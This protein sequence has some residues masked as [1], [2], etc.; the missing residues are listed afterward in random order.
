MNEMHEANRKYWD[1]ATPKW[2][3]LDDADWRKCPQKPS[4]AFEGNV[5]DMINEFIGNLEG[6]HACVIGSGDNYA[7]FALAGLGAVVTSTDI[8]EQ[9]LKVAEQRANILGLDIHFV[10]CDA[11]DLASIPDA[12]FDMVCSTNGFFVWIADLAGV[13]A[14]VNRNQGNRKNTIEVVRESNG[15][16]NLLPRDTTALALHN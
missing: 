3:E 11:A 6:K 5:L 2:Q 12:G 4:L 16:L 1:T 7:A 8:S 10:R 14:E 13:F 9:R 15:G